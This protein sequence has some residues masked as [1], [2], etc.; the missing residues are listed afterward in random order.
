MKKKL[1]TERARANTPAPPTPLR[2]TWIYL[3]LLL[4]TLAG[5]AQVRHFEFVNYDD[6]FYISHN[7]HVRDGVTLTGLRWALHSGEGANW[8]PITRLSHLLDAQFFGMQSGWH[9]LTN[10]LIHAFST[11]LLF[12]FPATPHACPMAQCFRG[13]SVRSAPPARGIGR[14]WVSGAQGRALAHFS[15]ML[16]LWLWTRGGSRIWALAAFCL[17]LMS[18]PMIVSLPLVLLLLDVWPLDRKRTLPWKKL[19]REK[20][21]FFALSTAAAIA[22][23]L[24]QRSSGAVSKHSGAAPVG[25]RIEN[26][27]ISYVV[28]AGKLFWPARLAVFYPYPVDIPLWQALL[29]A[30]VLGGITAVVVRCF[31]AYPYLTVGWFWYLVTLLPVIGIVQ[32]GGQARAD[33]YM[34]VPMI[35]LAI[36]LAWGGA[37]LLAALATRA[38]SPLS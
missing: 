25:L 10:L 29:A 17:G 19:L 18:K 28:Y 33:R 32:V 21:P 22:T 23:Y 37:D 15:R 26:A 11:L 34:Y 24:V 9:H 14:A 5:Y 7:V 1:R 35:G 3:A 20:V 36:M 30:I 4:S 31:A 38:S 13:V 16:S 27:L 6:P 2:S 12:A 8:F